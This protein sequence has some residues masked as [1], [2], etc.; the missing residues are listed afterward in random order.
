MLDFLCVTSYWPRGR[1]E[2]PWDGSN[3]VLLTNCKDTLKQETTGSGYA[4][5]KLRSATDP[6]HAYLPVRE[7]TELMDNLESSRCLLIIYRQSSNRV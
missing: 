5:E 4:L 6:L 3:V 7:T 2:K 1:L